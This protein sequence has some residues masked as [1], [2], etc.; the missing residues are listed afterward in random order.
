MYPT[1][2][3]IA[4]T[5]LLVA[6]AAA[7]CVAP[8]GTIN[9]RTTET[10][11]FYQG[12][13]SPIWG[14]NIYLDATFTA[15]VSVTGIGVFCLDGNVNNP[16][17][18]ALPDLT[19]QIFEIELWASPVGSTFVGNTNS[20][21]GGATA[22]PPLPPGWTSLGKGQATMADV[23]V[24]RTFSVAT[25]NTPAAFAPGTYA[26]AI[27]VLPIIAGQPNA[28]AATHPLYAG[29]TQNPGIATSYSDEF[30][31]LQCGVIQP[32]AFQGG[33]S[34]NPRIPCCELFYSTGANT[35][36]S[37]SYG[38]GCY[39]RPQSFYES[40]LNPVAPNVAHLDIDP[41]GSA[42]ALNGLDMYLVGSSFVVVNN[43]T[44]GLAVTPGSSPLAQQINTL[45]PATTGSPA[46]P[47][48]DAVSATLPLGFNFPHPANPVGSNSITISSNGIVYFGTS[49]RTYSFYDQ[50]DGFM[51]NEAAIAAAWCDLD[52]EDK[53]TFLGGAGD[54]WFDTDGVTYGAV[55]W[56][57]CRMWN[58]PTNISTIQIVFNASGTCS[59]RYGATGVSFSDSPVLVGYS[60]GNSA[61]DPS[62]G[63]P[64]PRQAP[65]I[66]V[67]AGGLG[68]VSGDGIQSSHVSLA[69]RPKAGSPLTINT[70]NIDS[71]ALASITLISSA[72]LPGIDL[73]IINMPGCNAYVTLPEV[74]SQFSFIGGSG[75]DSWAATPSIPAAFAGVQL[76]AQSVHLHIA[77]P[78]PTNAAL[79][80]VSDGLCI[81]FD[82]F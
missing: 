16:T 59:I 30:V 56:L 1:L 46:Q 68:Y 3:Q 69:N 57:N 37:S 70:T 61:A 78:L 55:T 58:E 26:I 29:I 19:G 2:L 62:N 51:A 8:S 76:Y 48:D 6:S 7:Q 12:T 22:Y 11:N 63:G 14:S 81:G 72:S 27:N 82:L 64:T 25:L 53:N 32:V 41:V 21:V 34:A 4:A 80:T 50:Y 74:A 33:T 10:S 67:A 23:R 28:G 49:S 9:L 73:G 71:S 24:N 17:F 5:T 77:G 13:A 52:P 36:F 40:W 44:P 38:K 20:G 65:D 43:T 35:A 60:A 31:S 18:Y 15:N 47:W 45:A 42:G 54:I 75:S 79:I 66:S 39:D